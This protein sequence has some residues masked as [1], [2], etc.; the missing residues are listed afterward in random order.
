MFKGHPKGLFVAFF[1]NMGERFGFYTMVSIFVL[2]MQA[3]YGLSAAAA[4]SIYATF[5]VGV[6]SF[7][8]LGGFLADRFLGYGRTISLGLVVMFIGYVLLA[9]PTVMNTGF[10][11]VVAALAVVAFGTG[12]FKGN[13]QALVGCM[14]D[15]P[16]YSPLRDRAFNVFYMGINIGA[17][18]AP[19]ASMA[20]CN[21]IMRQSGL[22]YDARIPAL[23]NDFLKSKL[24]DA[25]SFLTIAQG[26]DPAVTL[27]TLGAFATR[28]INQLSKSY[29]FGFGVACLSLIISMAIFWGFRKHYKMADMTERQKAKSEAH[30]A[31]VVELTPAQ[32]RERLVA[33]GLV[34]GVVIFFWMAFHQSAVT[35]TYFARDYT[36]PSVG[37]ATNLLF[38]MTGL[39]PA[40]LSLLGLFFLLRKASG[41]LARLLG[42]AAFAIFGALT[43]LRYSGYDAVN[44]FQ[45]QMFQHFNPFFIVVLTPLVIGVFGWLNRKGKEPSA[46]RKIG[47]GML[48]TAVAYAIL[49]V[50]SISLMSPKALGGQVAPAASQVSVYWLISTYFMLTIAELFLSPIGISFVS[51][52]AP[53]KY[54]GLMQ[55]GWF[56]ATAVGNSLV[57]VTAFFWERLPLWSVWAILAGACVLSAAFIFSIMKRLERAAQA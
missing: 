17:M 3:K 4:G 35:L 6:Y 9:L 33:L 45:P 22:A 27:D 47:L 1:A 19:S 20:V 29:H 46:P 55:G 8:L 31:Q 42:G 39:L 23:A 44:P 52:V 53:P 12:L 41:K 43:Y 37:K 57:G 32:T 40:F 14:Y 56:A 11:L 34:F 18:F 13:L 5:L 2:F 15:D 51:K 10:P 21:W 48:M 28:Y 38:D 7:P 24:A 26:Q 49:L 54:K 16:K 36:V 50:G 30:K 25:S